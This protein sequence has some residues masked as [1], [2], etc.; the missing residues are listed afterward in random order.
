MSRGNGSYAVTVDAAGNL[1]GRGAWLHPTRQCLDA[2]VRRRAFSRALRIAGS[3]DTA[4]VAEHLG[5]AE[6]SSSPEPLTT[7]QAM[8]NMST[9]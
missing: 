9:P 1:P 7:E 8:K 2:A 5:V 3:P 6:M 4:P